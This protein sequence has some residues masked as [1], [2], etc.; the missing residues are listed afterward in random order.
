MVAPG[1]FVESLSRE[2]VKF[3]TGVPDSLL[4]E[5]CSYLTVLDKDSHIIAANEGSAV[6]LACG[7]HLATSSVPLV[8]MQNSGLGN[9][10][11]P[12]MSL[13][14]PE[15]YGIPLVLLIGWRGEPGKKDEP[16]HVKQGR[17]SPALLDAME[18]PYK[19]LTGEAGQATDFARWAV[20]KARERGGP[21]ALLVHKGAF[22]KSG[23]CREPCDRDKLPL[24]R[25]EAISLVMD[26]VKPETTI[27]STTGMISRELYELRALKKQKRNSDFLTVGSMGHASQIALGI[28]LA[29]PQSEVICLDGDGAA[30]M[31]TGGFGSIGASSLNN[32][33]H[34]VLNNGAHDSVGG[35]PTVAFA[36]SL[37]GIAK[38]CGYTEVPEPVST[39]EELADALST[40]A[41]TP[42][43]RFLEVRVRPGAR[44]DIGR[45]KESPVENKR[46]FMQHLGA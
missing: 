35:Q 8:Y 33:L 19:C 10:V 5:F 13:A 34:I 14:D 38:A 18:I 25:E 22:D 46:L 6:A 41:A 1:V 21:V 4:K 7:V 24:S 36:V 28:A 39:K 12:L 16:Q 30:L 43:R 40:L 31:H 32:Y 42:G 26:A 44:A 23:I 27:V 37:A 29:K 11:N 17:V 2:G 9:S 15:V 45:P 20:N 3:F